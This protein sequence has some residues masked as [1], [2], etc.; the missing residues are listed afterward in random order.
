MR[1][2]QGLEQGQLSKEKRTERVKLCEQET[3]R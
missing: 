3:N 2:G 1:K